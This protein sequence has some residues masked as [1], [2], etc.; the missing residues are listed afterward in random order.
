MSRRPADITE[1]DYRRAIRAG[2]REHAASVEVHHPNGAF[3]I[4]R[5]TA[6]DAPPLVPDEEIVL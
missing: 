4:Y 5:L 1:A 6:V 3:V 2:K